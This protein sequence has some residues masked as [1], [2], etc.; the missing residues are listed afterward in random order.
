M[1][2]ALN[3]GFSTKQTWFAKRVPV[4]TGHFQDEHRM[5]FSHPRPF[6]VPCCTKK[7]GAKKDRIRIMLDSNRSQLG[8]FGSC[9]YGFSTFLGL[10]VPI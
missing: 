9:F 3:V 7:K 6:V 4:P 5:D 10:K 2:H 1:K 8:K